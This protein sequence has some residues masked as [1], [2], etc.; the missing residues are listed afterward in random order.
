MESKVINKMEE[1]MFK[2][3]EI[4]IPMYVGGYQITG[5]GSEA[6]NVRFMFVKK[7]NIINRFFCRILLGWVWI[8]NV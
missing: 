2:V 7:P 5:K 3:N 6:D 1:N 8:D 4:K